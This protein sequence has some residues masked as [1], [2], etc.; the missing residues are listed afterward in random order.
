MGR[1]QYDQGKYDKLYEMIELVYM[2]NRLSN[3]SYLEGNSKN[4]L[5]EML[6]DAL[7]IKYNFDKYKPQDS[8]T[9]QPKVGLSRD[10]A[11]YSWGTDRKSVV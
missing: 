2:L 1:E 10:N 3:N 6:N 5:T 9:N 4:Q 8:L 11:Y 7:S